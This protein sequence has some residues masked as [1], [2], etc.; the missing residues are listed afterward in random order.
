MAQSNGQK[1]TQTWF[2]LSRNV[3]IKHRFWLCD[4]TKCKFL[5]QSIQYL[6]IRVY[7]QPVQSC[8]LD[9]H[10]SSGSEASWSS[11]WFDRTQD[12]W[13]ETHESLLLSTEDKTDERDVHNWRPGE[14]W[15]QIQVQKWRKVSS[16]IRRLVG[17]RG[18][19]LL[20]VLNRI[21]GIRYSWNMGTACWLVR[22]WLPFVYLI[23]KPLIWNIFT[24]QFS[25]IFAECESGD[26]GWKKSV[27]IDN[28]TTHTTSSG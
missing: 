3:R 26:A 7:I 25:N 5:C 22:Y 1:L 18:S 20:A 16:R 23:V 11:W 9:T 12:T 10:C 13:L 17:I 21:W 15:W 24:N 27:N 14:E 28:G 2:C 8:L 6:F 4:L 19:P